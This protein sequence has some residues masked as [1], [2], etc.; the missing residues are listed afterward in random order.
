[1]GHPLVVVSLQCIMHKTHLTSWWTTRTSIFF[2]ILSS[3]RSG[4]GWTFGSCFV[5]VGVACK[6]EGGGIHAPKLW[7][8]FAWH[9]KCFDFWRQ[10]LKQRTNTAGKGKLSC[11]ELMLLFRKPRPLV[12]DSPS[13]SPTTCCQTP[14]LTHC[15]AFDRSL[16]GPRWRTD[17]VTFTLFRRTCSENTWTLLWDEH[18]RI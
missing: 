4:V 16:A 13:P 11:E 1:M 10:P 3:A 6:K 5:H 18:V 17:Y 7:L 15:T 9:S 14:P 12:L 8:G 2:V